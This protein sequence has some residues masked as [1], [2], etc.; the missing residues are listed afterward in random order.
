MHPASSGTLM[1]TSA[2]IL[3]TVIVY[4]RQP[5]DTFASLYELRVAE[6]RQ[7]VVRLILVENKPALLW[8]YM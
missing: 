6:F 3:Y 5:A 2:D 8:K 7:L 4:A 1:K